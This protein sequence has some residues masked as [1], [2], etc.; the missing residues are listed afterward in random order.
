VLTGNTGGVREF[1]F[2]AAA[3]EGKLAHVAESIL[4]QY[5]V[6]YVRP[7]GAGTPKIVQVRVGRTGLTVRAPAWP[8]Q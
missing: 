5:E 3:I 7:A 8:P 2:A 4:G 6:S 1:I